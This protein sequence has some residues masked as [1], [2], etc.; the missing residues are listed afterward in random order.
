MTFRRK[1]LANACFFI[2]C[3]FSYSLSFGFNFVRK[4][5]VNM[6]HRRVPLFWY[7][8]VPDLTHI[9]IEH[10]EFQTHNTANY[11][12]L[13]LIVNSVFSPYDTH[14]LEGE[15]HYEA[16]SCLKRNPSGLYEN[17][18][19]IMILGMSIFH[20]WQYSEKFLPIH[21]A[22]I[23][24]VTGTYNRS[25]CSVRTQGTIISSLPYF[26]ALGN[27]SY[28]TNPN[29]TLYLYSW[30]ARFSGPFCHFQDRYFCTHNS[31]VKFFYF[32]NEENTGKCN[33]G[34]W[35]T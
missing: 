15:T 14:E 19:F 5:F 3:G 22:A 27:R 12:L 23:R 32:L 35:K 9:R 10:I 8:V 1:K 6:I 2:L 17:S 16:P 4:A 31:G 7:I 25:I 24:N 33:H 20:I 34:Q 18:F 11:C 29:P 21:S 28:P 13:H 26:T 30:F